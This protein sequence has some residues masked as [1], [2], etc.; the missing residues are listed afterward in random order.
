MYLVIPSDY[1]SIGGIKVDRII[2]IAII[3]PEY[4]AGYKMEVFSFYSLLYPVSE[5]L[6]SLQG[7]PQDRLRINHQLRSLPE[8]CLTV[9]RVRYEHPAVLFKLVIKGDIGLDH[10]N[11]DTGS[12]A[13]IPPVLV[14]IYQT[15]DD[16]N[17]HQDGCR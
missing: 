4:L 5:G 9:I 12:M 10:G 11:I 1:L 8:I 7:P 2:I 16:N 14:N 15:V 3:I 17:Y 6:V 13:R